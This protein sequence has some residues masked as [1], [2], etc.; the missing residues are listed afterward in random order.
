MIY[1][2]ETKSF[3]PSS[4]LMVL[5]GEQLIRNSGIAVFELVKNAY[6]ADSK[7]VEI[8]IRDVENPDETSIVV[9]DTGTGMDYDTVTG[10]WLEPGTDYRAKQKQRNIRTP[11]F[12]R[13]PLG[14]KGIG[15]F[16]VHK[17]GKY[18]SM[19]TRK[20]GCPEVVVNI[21]WTEFQL[22]RYLKDAGVKVI[23]REPRVFKGSSTGTKIIIKNL[24]DKWTRGMV[25]ELH[26][27][28]FS[29]CS[30][31]T[32]PGEFKPVFKLEPEPPKWL[33]DMLTIENVMKYSMFNVIGITNGKEFTYNYEFKP[34]PGMGRIM[35]R[36]TKSKTVSLKEDINYP[37]LQDLDIGLIKIDLR[38]FDRDPQILLLS[39][40]DKQGFKDFLNKNGGIRVYRDGI[41]IFDYGEPG[42]DWLDL[43][44]GRASCRERV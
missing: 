18:V 17:L 31:F 4:R 14:E 26:R 7:Q 8:I 27:S 3:E 15:R 16:A 38:I 32:A 12:K 37:S 43:E 40:K 21:N 34:L 36:K 19:V 22:H 5:L 35:G 24:N 23:E 13:L 2:S 6:D 33:D 30:P 39:I 41:R 25:R 44:I 9:K 10:V 1:R 20:S 42:N 29:I 11:I 28:I